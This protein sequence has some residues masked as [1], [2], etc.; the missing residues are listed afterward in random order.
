MKQLFSVSTPSENVNFIVSFA[1]PAGET[2]DLEYVLN[3]TPAAKIWLGCVKQAQKFSKIVQTRM[4]DFPNKDQAHLPAM[5]DRLEAVIA[6]LAV[7][8]PALLKDK[9][10]RS[11]DSAIQDS[12]NML[13]R[14]FAHSHLIEKTITHGNIKIWEEFNVLIHRIENEVLLKRDYVPKSDLFRMRVEFIWG[15]NQKVA[16]PEIC[17]NDFSV[18]EEFGDVQYVYCQ[19]GRHLREIHHAHDDHV[20]VEHIQPHRF[21]SADTGL[22]FGPDLVGDEA[23]AC[24]RII[25][26]WFKKHEAKFAQA[27]VTWENPNKTLGAVCVAKLK[28]RPTTTAEKQLFQQRLSRFNQV[29]EIV[30]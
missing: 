6:L 11:S 8:F 12:M 30:F 9:I 13:H 18:E 2:L 28:N 7:Q 4:Y 17:Y 14:N 20:L 26:S 5:L 27:G 10:D 3:A 16:I 24:T 1:N 22:C 25:H 29:R 21:F 15:Y 23:K 19:V